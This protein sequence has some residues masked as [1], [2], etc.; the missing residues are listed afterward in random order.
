MNDYVFWAVCTLGGWGVGWFVIGPVWSWA[1]D[2]I[3][4]R[5]DRREWLRSGSYGGDE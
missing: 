3:E 2:R 4:A 1:A 5:R